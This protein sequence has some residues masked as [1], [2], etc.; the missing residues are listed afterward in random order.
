MVASLMQEVP[1][2]RKAY[3]PYFD[4]AHRGMGQSLGSSLGSLLLLVRL[5]H[6]TD[7]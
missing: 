1:D 5:F 3:T 4:P 7:Y 6:K 2:W